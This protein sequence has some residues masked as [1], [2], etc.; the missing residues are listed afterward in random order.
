MHGEVPGTFPGRHVIYY[1]KHYCCIFFNLTL[2][3]MLHVILKICLFYVLKVLEKRRT[4]VLKTSRKDVHRL[5]S[6]GHRQGVNVKVII[7]IL[8]CCIIFNLISPNVCLKYQRYSCFMSQCFWGNNQRRPIKAAKVMFGGWCSQ[9]VSRM[10]ILNIFYKT[11]FCLKV[12][13]FSSPSM[14]VKY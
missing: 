7:P 6:L 1:K 10:S 4:N 5:M 11:Y 3:N 9:D 2:T 13:N 12:F 14:C 8:F